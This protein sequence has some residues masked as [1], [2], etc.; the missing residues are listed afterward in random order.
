MPVQNK[1]YS[2]FHIIKSTRMHSTFCNECA[3]L[4]G[5]PCA[6]DPQHMQVATPGR[7]AGKTLPI[8]LRP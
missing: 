6:D 4:H 2:D 7:H 8:W 1:M 3:W 5:H